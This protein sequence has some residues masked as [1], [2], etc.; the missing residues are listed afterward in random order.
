MNSTAFMSVRMGGWVGGG[1]GARFHFLCQEKGAS[2]D[3]L[4]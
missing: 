4:T 3:A 2:M 1:G